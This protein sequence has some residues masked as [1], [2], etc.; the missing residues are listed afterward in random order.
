[1][2]RLPH[3]L[4]G[5]LVATWLWGLATGVVMAQEKGKNGE[6]ENRATAKSERTGPCSRGV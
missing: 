4:T 2:K 1:M 6:G 3:V 5:P